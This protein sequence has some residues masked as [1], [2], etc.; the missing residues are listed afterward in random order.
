MCGGTKLGIKAPGTTLLLLLMPLHLHACD[1]HVSLW[2][3]SQSYSSGT[4]WDFHA[5][6]WLIDMSAICLL[7]GEA[8]V[9][10]KVQG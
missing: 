6:H 4:S 8:R 10:D 9:P 7:A 1:G 5:R 3:I 2:F